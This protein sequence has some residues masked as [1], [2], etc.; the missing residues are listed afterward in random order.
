MEITHESKN[1]ADSKKRNGKFGP[2]LSRHIQRRLDQLEASE[3]LGAFARN[4]PG[5]RC[6][7]YVGR[8]EGVY[9][10]NLTG[11]YRLLFRPAEDPP[12]KKPDGGIDIEQVTAIVI[13]DVCDPH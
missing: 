9:S 13:I 11:N 6:H 1:T 2:E 3:S 8:G 7:E 4:M 10:V 12:P 5:A